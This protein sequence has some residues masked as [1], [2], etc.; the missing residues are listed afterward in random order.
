MPMKEEIVPGITRPLVHHD[1]TSRRW[2]PALLLATEIVHGILG[3]HPV[4]VGM[5]KAVELIAA[6]DRRITGRPKRR[7]KTQAGKVQPLILG[8]MKRLGRGH[9]LGQV[10]IGGGPK[11]AGPCGRGILAAQSGGEIR[12]TRRRIEL[13]VV[14]WWESCPVFINVQMQ[15]ED[16]LMQIVP[17]LGHPCRL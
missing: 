12:A 17:A 15:A 9:V 3:S 7:S 8:T 16:Y 4:G 6:A 5:D 2:H 13:S 10:P 14:E 1:K 11:P